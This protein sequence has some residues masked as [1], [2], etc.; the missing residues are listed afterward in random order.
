MSARTRFIALV[1]VAMGIGV[2]LVACKTSSKSS[3]PQSSLTAGQSGTGSSIVNAA[4]SS[5]PEIM[6]QKAKAKKVSKPPKSVPEPLKHGSTV[7]E[8]PAPTAGAE[9]VTW[10]I[11]DVNLDGSANLEEGIAVHDEA[12]DTLFVWWEDV[13]DLMGDGVLDTFEGF[14]WISD[15]TV[16]FIID[17]DDG[18]EVLACVAASSDSEA[19]SGCIAC[20]AAGNYEVIA[21]EEVYSR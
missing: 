11:V 13:F 3:P 5:K 19:F 10:E 14:L 20:D 9:L 1:L 16:G 4:K 6:A 7:I 8:P 12:T 18:L 2:A 21:L 17:L 15:D